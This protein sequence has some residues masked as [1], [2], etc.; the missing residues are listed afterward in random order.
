MIKLKKVFTRILFI[1]LLIIVYIYRS[2]IVSF[3]I[4]TVTDHITVEAPND[5]NYKKD[6][7]FMLVQNTSNYHAKNKQDILNI[8]YTIL[9]SGENNFTFYCAKDYSSCLNDIKDI[10]ENQNLLSTINNMISPYN[11]Y[12]KLYITTTTYGKAN[13]TINKLYTSEEISNINNKIEQIKSEIITDNMSS[14]VKLLAYHDYLVNNTVYDEVRAEDIKMNNEQNNSNNSHKATGPLFEGMAL[15]SGYSD[16]MKIFID[17]L[18]IPNYKVSTQN[19]VW[20]ALY[21]DNNWLHIDLTW[22]D[23][24]T[25]NHSNVL[26]HNYFL[27]DT[28][29]LL[30]L[31]MT[32]H[33]FNKE[34]YPE[35]N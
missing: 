15:C 14:K 18:N 12:E 20:N 32:S 28:N 5:N 3:T 31:D 25:S 16:A 21:L 10:S 6:Y 27:I 29:A 17:Q 13:I 8:I 4:N 9:N 2:E 1:I 30:S 22:D 34:Y 11:S 33:N 26:L 19:H 35:L 23:P 7:N 24:V